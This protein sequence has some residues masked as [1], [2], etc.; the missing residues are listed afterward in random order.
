MLAL[1]WGRWHVHGGALAR[2]GLRVGAR[3]R[4]RRLLFFA[5]AAFRRLLPQLLPFLLLIVQ[6]QDVTQ[7]PIHVL[8]VRHA[9]RNINEFTILEELLDQSLLML[10]ITYLF[11]V[12][13]PQECL[14]LLPLITRRTH[15][16][17]CLTWLL[18][19][20]RLIVARRNI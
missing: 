13:L 11:L 15:C 4:I 1:A 10:L 17:H 19:I 7:E 16:R 3:G 14:L 9:G 2:A 18:E 5:V 8:L 12:S 20:R 6:F